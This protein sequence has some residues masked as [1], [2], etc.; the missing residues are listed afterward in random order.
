MVLSDIKHYLQDRKQATLS[1]LIYH[2]DTDREAMQSMLDHWI[3]KGR[4][5][6]YD[7]RG[8]CGRE[9]PG[10]GCDNAKMELYEWRA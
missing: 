10:C 6:R 9:C 3:Q 1:D 8:A 5:T 2:F 7:L 4:V